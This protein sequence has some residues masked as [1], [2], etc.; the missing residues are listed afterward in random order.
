MI[1]FSN[2]LEA[3]QYAPG[4]LLC[5]GDM[6]H[7]YYDLYSIDTVNSPNSKFGFET[8][9]TFDQSEIDYIDRY[10]I[11]IETGMI[12]RK[13]DQ[14][15][16]QIII[17]GLSPNKSKSSPPLLG[18]KYLSLGMICGKCEDYCFTIQM[19]IDLECLKLK[20]IFLKSEQI[21]IRNTEGNY[22][23]RNTYTDKITKY[24]FDSC[25]Q[26]FVYKNPYDTNKYQ[27]L[28]LIPLNRKNPVETLQRI[29]KLLIFT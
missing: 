10:S 4:C 20:K 24:L 28:P 11:F 16:N 29:K 9:F 1:E 26:L 21:S 6:K 22:N 15:K 8:A 12:E 19:I 13:C 14:N 27:E 7:R 5:Q 3:M 17:N 25:H 18:D 23:I 2:L